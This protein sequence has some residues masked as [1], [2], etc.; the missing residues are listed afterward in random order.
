MTATKNVASYG[1]TMETLLTELVS[2]TCEIERRLAGT[3]ELR[4]VTARWGHPVKPRGRGRRKPGTPNQGEARKVVLI[5]LR[6]GRRSARRRDDPGECHV[7]FTSC[8]AYRSGRLVYRG[9]KVHP[10]ATV[11]RS[12][13]SWLPRFGLEDADGN[14]GIHAEMVEHAL[15]AFAKAWDINA[16]NNGTF[17]I[18]LQLL[19]SQEKGTRGA[20]PSLLYLRDAFGAISIIVGML[21]GPNPSRGRHQTMR[22]ALAQV[23]VS[24]RLPLKNWRAELTTNHTDLWRAANRER[25]VQQR[26]VQNATLSRPLAN[27]ENWLLHLD[28][29]TNATYLLAL[30]V[31]VQGYLLE[32]AIWLADLMVLR[33][34]DYEGAYFNPDPALGR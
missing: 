19:R 7:R 15:T 11:H 26:E 27:V 1:V 21:V 6:W 16:N 33:V 29:P 9:Y 10:Y 25:Q 34:I 17:H 22:E 2:M 20:D 14:I 4:E 32:V 8:K 13:S 28:D 24:D 30:P 31:P 12:G 3:H 5:A 23:K 18:A